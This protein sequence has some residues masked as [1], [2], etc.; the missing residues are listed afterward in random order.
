MGI[1]GKAVGAVKGFFVHWN[2][3]GEGDYVSSKEIVC[4]SVG[5]I[6]V[7]FV[8][9]MCYT[10]AMQASCLLIGSEYSGS[11]TTR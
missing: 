6:G 2:S 4:Y 7:Q 9:A 8:A 3:P 5:G 10:I 11:E 1:I